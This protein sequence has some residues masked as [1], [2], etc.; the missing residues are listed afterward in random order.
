MPDLTGRVALVTGSTS[1]IGRATAARLASDGAFVIVSGRDPERGDS[2][3]E[4]IT[5]NGGQAVFIG[6]DLADAESA[7]ALATDALAVKGQ[8]DILV[9]NAGIAVSGST[10]DGTENDFDAL[11]A[12]NVKAPYFLVGQIVPTMIER[13]S[14]VVINVS[15]MVASFG[16]SSTA[17]Y[18]SSK[19]AL[20]QLT[21]DWAVEFGP[22]GVR[23]NT[24]APGPTRTEATERVMGPLLHK[25]AARSPLGRPA[26]PD[27]VAAV[28]AFLAGD[29]A[30]MVHGQLIHVDGG[31][32]IL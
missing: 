16:S 29:D 26:T 17:I 31:R 3:V 25:L 11:Y 10:A 2:V 7:I 5:A 27:E 4:A 15:T 24:V 21:R 9:N 28:V 1:G 6:A 20:N 13:G 30:A 18:G 8:V 19:A 32:S 23:V 12:L 14:G 22:S